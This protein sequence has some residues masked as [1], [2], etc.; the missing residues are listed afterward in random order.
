MLARVSCLCSA[1]LRRLCDALRLL[2]PDVIPKRFRRGTCCIV[3]GV[4]RVLEPRGLAQSRF[5]NYC[6]RFRRSR[7]NPCTDRMK[8][9]IPATLST[10]NDQKKKNAPLYFANSTVKIPL[11]PT[12]W[13]TGMAMAR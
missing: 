1:E 5:L 6:A 10:K 2:F 13:K 4:L 11:G 8:E 3:F 12:M 9:N 7:H